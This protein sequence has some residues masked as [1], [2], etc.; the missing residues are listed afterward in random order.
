MKLRPIMSLRHF[1]AF[2]LPSRII[3]KNFFA[4]SRVKQNPIHVLMDTFLQMFRYSLICTCMCIFWKKKLLAVVIE[5]L[6]KQVVTYFFQPQ[7]S[8]PDVIIWMISGENRLAYYRCPAHLVLWSPNPE[9]RGRLCGHL[10]T[11]DLKVCS[12]SCTVIYTFLV[13]TLN[14]GHP[15]KCG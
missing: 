8:M 10:E 9:Y 2:S 11:I 14:R 15:T 6:V 3:E 13:T 5:L 7:N 1:C 4:S 12:R